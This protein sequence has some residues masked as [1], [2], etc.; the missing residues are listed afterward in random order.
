MSNRI[1][2][3]F[4]RLFLGVT[5]GDKPCIEIFN[6]EG[7]LVCT[8][9]KQEKKYLVTFEYEGVTYTYDNLDDLINAVTT[10]IQNGGYVKDFSKND[11]TYVANGTFYLQAYDIRNVLRVLLA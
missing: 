8:I 5:P 9:K 7:F 3:F 1:N 6:E 4:R 10:C 2:T 11:P